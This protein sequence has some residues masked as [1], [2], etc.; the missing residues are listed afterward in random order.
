MFEVFRSRRMAAILLLGF[1]SGLPLYLTSR[2]LQAW[3]TVAG[4]NLTA[5]GLFSL[6][7][8]PY[9][10]KFLWS[11]VIDRFTFPFLGRR[12]G[13]LFATQVALAIAIAAMALQ[14]PAQALE[15]LAMNAFAI[16]F[17]SATQD[18][19][20][21]AYSTDVCDSSEVG[22]GSG[23]KVLGYR[24]AMIAAGGGALVMA[25]FFSW[26]AVYLIFALLMLS[27]AI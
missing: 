21:D 9:S 15:L 26:P 20:I 27:L 11:P 8:L 23:T 3:M 24:I 6:V 17:L 18:V 2:T 25:D 13:W 1:S 22:A 19:T 4:V 14:R 12:K 5:I 16:A 7:S 10:L